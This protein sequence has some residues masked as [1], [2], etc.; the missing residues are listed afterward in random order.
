P[1]GRHDE[2]VGPELADVRGHARGGALADG[3]ERNH[4]SDADHDPEHRE[5]RAQ[6]VA[7]NLTE[8]H[9][10]RGPDHAAPPRRACPPG[11]SSTM[12]PSRNTTTRET[13]T[14]MS[15][16]CV[17]IAMVMPCSTLSRT[18][19]SMIS[20]LRAESRLPVGSS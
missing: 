17:T 15:G 7:P 18:S 8:R 9:E 1:T 12:R 3:H 5:E 14:S 10:Q 11:R 20:T 13:Y 16:S 6:R 19:S 2:Q 4:G